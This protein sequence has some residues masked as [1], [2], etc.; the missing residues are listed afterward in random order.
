MWHQFIGM[1]DIR[2]RGVVIETCTK[3]PESQDIGVRV[4]VSSRRP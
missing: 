4:R 3:V 1:E 2:M